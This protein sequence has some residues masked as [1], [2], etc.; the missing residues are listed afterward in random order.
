MPIK[1]FEKE[2]ECVHERRERERGREGERVLEREGGREGERGREGE[3][4]NKYIFI[5]I[6]PRKNSSLLFLRIRIRKSVYTEIIYW[7]EG[8]VRL[9][10]LG[11]EQSTP[12]QNNPLI[13][14]SEERERGGRGRGEGEREEDG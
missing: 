9:S 7:R 12:Y 4:H 11:F 13:L 8:G 6:V 10:T 5:F 1:H 14:Q 2:I 3:W